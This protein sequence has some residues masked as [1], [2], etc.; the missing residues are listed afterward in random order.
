M[1]KIEI[2]PYEPRHAYEI[3]DRN[4]REEDLWLSTYPDWDKWVVAWQKAGPA[5][6]LLIDDKVI[7]CAGVILLEWLKGEA[8]MLLSND[9]YQ[10]KK[11][12]FK[13]IKKY[14]IEIIHIFKL[15][16][17]QAI[18]LCNLANVEECKRFLKHLGFKNETPDGLAAYGPNG[19]DV[20]LFGRRC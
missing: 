15:R 1:K 11:T 13:E 17:L 7:I 5:Y 18:I 9:F 19:E 14:L 20:F 6:S 10:Y 16:R 4:V 2:I 8:W 12:C 3:L